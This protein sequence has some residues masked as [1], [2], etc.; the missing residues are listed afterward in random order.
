MKSDTTTTDANVVLITSVIADKHGN[1]AHGHWVARV[2]REKNKFRE[3]EWDYKVLAPKSLADRWPSFYGASG[4]FVEIPSRDESVY[5]VG[6]YTTASH[7][8]L[9][10]SLNAIPSYLSDKAARYF[11]ALKDEDDERQWT[12]FSDGLDVTAKGD[13]QR[14]LH[15]FVGGPKAAGSFFSIQSDSK[16]NKQQQQQK[17]E[18]RPPLEDILAITSSLCEDAGMKGMCGRGHVGP[19]GKRCKCGCYFTR[20]FA[21]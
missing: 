5:K 10:K 21:D 8:K 19:F 11:D 16:N 3:H 9:L 14:K 4:M 17:K 18:E 7:Y 12:C 1:T 15:T 20:D 2:R 13:S 6:Y